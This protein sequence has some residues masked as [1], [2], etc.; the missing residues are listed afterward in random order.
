[1][2]LAHLRHSRSPDK[3]HRLRI[4]LRRVRYLGGFFEDALG[5]PIRKLGRRS[6]SV[7]GV[8]GEI[9]DAD[10]ALGRILREGPTPPRLLVKNLERLR[11]AD[12]EEL[13]AAWR[14]FSDLRF[15][16]E[17]DALLEARVEE[18]L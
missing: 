9:R 17:V 11:Q 10:L 14:R 15:R 3:L 18:N 5:R 7:E 2:K 1:M 8:L 13:D 12:A 4:A 16:S 6:H